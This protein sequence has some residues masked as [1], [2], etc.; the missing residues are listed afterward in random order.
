MKLLIFL[1]LFQ[2]FF[3]F[4]V[5]SCLL[6]ANDASA[7]EVSEAY[8]LRYERWLNEQE[9]KRQAL[10]ERLNAQRRSVK[11]K[12]GSLAERR[13]QVVESRSLKNL[14]APVITLPKT[15]PAKAE[16]LSSPAREIASPKKQDRLKTTTSSKRRIR[17]AQE[18]FLNNM[19]K[20]N[21]QVQALLTMID[22]SKVYFSINAEGQLK[23]LFKDDRF[24]EI[25]R[26]EMTQPTRKQTYN[27][28]KGMQDENRN[29][30]EPITNK[31]KR[32]VKITREK[33]DTYLETT[34]IK[35]KL[36]RALQGRYP[37]PRPEAQPSSA[38]PMEGTQSEGA[39]E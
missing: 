1:C 38:G 14:E 5:G 28:F 30:N 32:D 27:F 29:P 11:N 31:L 34:G 36:T 13:R 3:S 26:E 20:D 7:S 33:I 12:E 39:T 37:A 6:F 8:D 9:R 2:I 25:Y 23:D 16:S 19:P 17:D 18:E 35:S 21:E 10:R 22:H 24:Q 4:R 15:L